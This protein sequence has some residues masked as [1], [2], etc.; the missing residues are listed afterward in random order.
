MDDLASVVGSALNIKPPAPKASEAGLRSAA[1]LTPQEQAKSD[2]FEKSPGNIAELQ[3]AIKAEKD[4]G[5]RKILE[6]E[7][8]KQTSDQPFSDIASVV[9]SAM[10]SQPSTTTASKAVIEQAKAT[11]VEEQSKLASFGAGAG[12]A[13]GTGVLA[14]Q[15]LAGK[16]ISYLGELGHEKGVSDI[17]APQKNMAQ[18][19]GDWLSQ[20]ASE[21]LKKLEGEN[22]PYAAANPKTNL[23]GEI[24]G[25]VLSPVNKLVPGFGGPAATL[26]GAAMKGAAQGA[27][28]N[29]LTAPVTDDS[30]PFL[31]EKAKQAGVGAVGGTIGSTLGFGITKGVNAALDVAKRGLTRLTTGDASKAADTVVSDVLKGQGLDK[32]NVTPELFDGIKAQV[33]EAIKNGNKVDGEALSRLTQAQTLPVPVPMLKGQLTRDPMQYAKEMN[34]RGIKGVGEP[35]TETMQAQNKALIANLDAIGGNKGADVVT[36]GKDLIAP[37]QAID[38]QAQSGV[39]ASYDAFKQATG[40][41]LDVPLQG[42]AQDYSKIAKDFEG[43]IP[44]GVKNSFEQYGLTGGKQLK[45]FNIEDAE[46]LIKNI[47]DHYSP[48]LRATDPGQANA[49]DKLRKAVQSTIENGAGASAEGTAAA[50]LAKAARAAARERFQTIDNTPALKAAIRGAEPDKFIQKY[51]LQGN[52]SEIESLVNVLKKDNPQALESLQ[53]ALVAHIKSR[54]LNGNS[55]ENGVFSQAQMK[56]FSENPN[57][58]ARLSPVLGPEKMQTLRQLNKVAEDVLY[59]PKASAVNTS[60]TASAAANIVKEEVQGGGLNRLLEIGKRIP[61]TSGAASY[62]Q[63]GV[64]ANRASNL[65]EESVNPSLGQ[66]GNTVTLKDLSRLGARTGSAY[67]GTQSQKKSQ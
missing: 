55:A 46:N 32:S 60:N 6:D 41:E 54:V 26:T 35:I 30:K 42:L 53:D 27:I 51:I 31:L 36:A 66:A 3:Q 48:A 62:A 11:P 49:L 21:G 19:L 16:G 14:I 37:L 10:T 25:A 38:K 15:Q 4:P 9:G 28:L 17:V 61:G 40:R 58:V 65:I 22:A 18:K 52:Q 39:R 45:T 24:T 64:Q 8:T 47:N 44:S 56:S 7:L 13:V 23:G 12:K 29:T 63:Q 43:K 33:Q 57:F 34:L 59:A 20:D 1:A 67:T 50:G 5:N 2:A